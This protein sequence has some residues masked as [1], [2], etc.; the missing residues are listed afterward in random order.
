MFDAPIR[1]NNIQANAN[2]VP[3]NWAIPGRATGLTKTIDGGQPLMES[4]AVDIAAI[5]LLRG[6]TSL[7]P[8]DYRPVPVPEPK[9][10]PFTV[11]M[12]EAPSSV[13]PK[14]RSAGANTR[15]K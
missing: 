9:F 14:A 8:S 4:P 13:N 7:L 11:W 5:S 12:V 15:P 2:I 10:W 6:L 3:V 1:V